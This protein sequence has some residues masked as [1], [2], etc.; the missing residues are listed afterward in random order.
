MTKDPGDDDAQAFEEAMRDARPL[1]RGHARVPARPAPATGAPRAAR[2]RS[3]SAKLLAAEGEL[4]SAAFAL[5]HEGERIEG[6]APGVDARTV[7]RLKSGEPRVEARLD[8]HG[9]ARE[10]ALDELERFVRSSRASGRRALL[11]IHGRGAN[12]PDGRAVL[13]PLVWRWLSSSRAAGAAVLA[14][15]SAPPAQGGDGA[16]LVLLRK[17]DR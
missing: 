11:I 3:E 9:R 16:T 12:T 15:V 2:E 8:L 14:F 6:R 4:E 1:A 5:T 17:P 13:K 7:R 10:A